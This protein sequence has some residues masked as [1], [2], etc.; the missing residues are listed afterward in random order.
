MKL[1]F[2]EEWLSKVCG[3][4]FEVVE[5]IEQVPQYDPDNP[6][7]K[8]YSEY[9]VSLKLKATDKGMGRLLE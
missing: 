2:L 4:N 3:D 6:L 7:D 8:S 1:D 5:F 9:Y